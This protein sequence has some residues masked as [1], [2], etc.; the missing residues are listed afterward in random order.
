MT[1]RQR[2]HELKER[3]GDERQ[4]RLDRDAVSEALRST[5]PS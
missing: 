4:P 1:E 3:I 2:H 5:R